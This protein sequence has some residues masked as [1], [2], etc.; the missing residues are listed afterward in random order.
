MDIDMTRRNKKPRPLSD[1]ERNKLE[2]FIDAIHYSAR[3][4]GSYS[5]YLIALY[6]AVRWA[7]CTNKLP[8]VDAN[9]QYGMAAATPTTTLNIATSSYLNK[10][11]RQYRRNTLTAHAAR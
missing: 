6:K 4:V 7:V 9:T 5:T 1:S 11:S 3:Y 8:G 10:C 2:E